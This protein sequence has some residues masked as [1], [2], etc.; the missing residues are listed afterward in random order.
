MALAGRSTSFWSWHVENTV[1]A[2]RGDA[3]ELHCA[4]CGV[5]LLR[6]CPR[7]LPSVGEA[8]RGVEAEVEAC[9]AGGAAEG[10]ILADPAARAVG[11]QLDAAPPVV[12]ERAGDG[13]FG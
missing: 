2:V 12:V 5:C 1:G 7:F 4:G 8:G 13:L 10:V 6:E 11:I 3:N 9:G